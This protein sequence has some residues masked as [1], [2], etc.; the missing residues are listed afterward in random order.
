MLENPDIL[1]T[2]NTLIRVLEESTD[3]NEILYATLTA[4]TSGESFGFNR[5]FVMLFEDGILKPRFA[6]GP[7]DRQDAER[8]WEELVEKNLT[9]DDLIKGYSHEKF[10]KEWNKLKDVFEGIIITREELIREN[11]EIE[12][13]LTERKARIVRMDNPELLEY[14]KFKNLKAREVAI[15]PLVTLKRELGVIVA[16]N[17]LTGTPIT[18][19]KIM[20]LE[21]FVFQASIA[22]SRAMLFK[23]IEEKDRMILELQ[24]KAI[25]QELIFKLSHEIKNPL[26]VLGGVVSILREEIPPD[27]KLRIYVDTIM[28][29]VIKMESIL[30]QTIEGMKNQLDTK[31]E[32]T[33]LAELIMEKIKEHEGFLKSRNIAIEF[34]PCGDIPDL[35]LPKSQLSEVFEYII[36]N[37]I[38]AM[39]GG[40]KIEIWMEREKGG[41]SIF[42]KDYGVGIPPEILPHI[43]DPFFTTKKEG[44]GLGL[45]NA[46]QILLG[47]GGDIECTSELGKGTVFKIFIPIPVP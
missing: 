17:F 23:Q 13:A 28:N 24:R 34:T 16:D 38:E 1:K 20:A 14:K 33:N 30:K 43:F 2:V 39:P 40:G 10:E 32:R 25:Y 5:A 9:L 27:H 45:Y 37:A 35:L 31:R 18:R 15:A 11:S 42:I 21:T 46:K 8:I 22:I 19:S 3:L 44:Y 36:I 29:S 6:L 12:R 41:V 47:L 26:T 4:V 7:L